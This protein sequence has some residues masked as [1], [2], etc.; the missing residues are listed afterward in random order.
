MNTQSLDA[1]ISRKI[2]CIFHKNF[3]GWSEPCDMQVRARMYLMDAEQYR[4]NIGVAIM[5]LFILS[6]VSLGCKLWELHG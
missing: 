3:R 2:C 4:V 1:R 5:L 6:L